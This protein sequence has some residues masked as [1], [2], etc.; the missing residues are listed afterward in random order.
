MEEIQL[1]KIFDSLWQ[2]YVAITP[3]A[4]SIKQLF[5]SRGE[6]V[7]NDHIAFRTFKSQTAG[8]NQLAEPFLK[9]GYREQGTYNFEQKKLRAKHYEFP[10]NRFPKIFISE[11]LVDE[12][13]SFLEETVNNCL[14]QISEADSQLYELGR[15]WSIQYSTYKRLKNES[16]Y[17]AW[18]Y[19]FGFRANHFTLSVNHL[20]T[21][22]TLEKV[23]RL[24]KD[25]GHGLNTAGGEIN[26]SAKSRLEQ[27]ST[28]A[29]NCSVKFDDG[30]FI[31]PSCYYEFARRYPKD[32]GEL[33]QGFITQSAD[34]IFES[35][36]RGQ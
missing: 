9:L 3:I 15:L 33:F 13:S 31:I 25:Q 29:Y 23:N 16:E 22:N 10:E 20:K 34:K 30:E 35:T 8:I 1:T 27:S 12:F 24:L 6:K 14:E 5:E 17:A 11:L 18:L 7:I 26:G 4:H 21:F 36:H 19:V 32:N 2:Q 28:L